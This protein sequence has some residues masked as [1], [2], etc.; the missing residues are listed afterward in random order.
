MR[1]TRLLNPV[2][3]KKV[4][5]P[6]AVKKK[7]IVVKPTVQLHPTVT[8]TACGRCSFLD[9]KASLCELFDV[10]VSLE[11]PNS[12]AHVRAENCVDA[13]ALG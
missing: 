6:V 3:E 9:R 2:V 7:G 8:A 4:P 11:S 13:E 1:Q 12:T 5:P 10:E